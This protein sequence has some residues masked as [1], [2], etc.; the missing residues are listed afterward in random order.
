[1]YDQQHGVIYCY[2]NGI[3][4]TASNAA[5]NQI[6]CLYVCVCIIFVCAFCLPVQRKFRLT[7]DVSIKLVM[8]ENGAEIDEDSE[9]TAVCASHH[10]LMF[11]LDGQQWS[12]VSKMPSEVCICCIICS[13]STCGFLCLVFNTF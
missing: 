11:L 12:R 2:C 10:P 9:L 8:D 7:S 5:W 3:V 13:H 4:S 6:L 1:M